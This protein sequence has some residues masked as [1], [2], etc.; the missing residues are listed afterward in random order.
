MPFTPTLTKE[1][2]YWECARAATKARNDAD[3]AAIWGHCPDITGENDPVTNGKPQCGYYKLRRGEGDKAKWVPAAIWISEVGEMLAACDGMRDPVKIWPQCGRNPI[4]YEDYT[5]AL[6]N[7]KFPGEVEAKLPRLNN[8]AEDPNGQFRQDM[9]SLLAQVEAFLKSLPDPVTEEG[10]HALANYQALVSASATTAKT[11]LD[12]ALVEKK[13][14]IKA[15]QEVWSIP[16]KAAADIKERIRKLITPFLVAKKA[17]GETLRL[18]GQGTGQG[19]AR[20]TGLKTYWYAEITDWDQAMQ[21]YSQHP[22]VRELVQTLANAA[23]RSKELREL[24]MD[25]ITFKSGDRAA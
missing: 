18:G 21:S 1:F 2:R 15:E 4:S 14:A 3:R 19:R 20:R 12:A 9:I 6:Q 8:F 24:P 16:M 13:A 22:Q 25:G 7:G 11:L 23:A 10:A 5:Y 17:D